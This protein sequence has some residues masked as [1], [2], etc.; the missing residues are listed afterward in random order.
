MDYNRLLNRAWTIVWTHKFLIGLGVVAAL[1]SGGNN[2][3][4]QMNDGNGASRSSF[5][6]G[7]ENFAGIS[8]VLIVLLIGLA[9]AVGLVLWVLVTVARGG[10]I[11]AVDTIDRGNNASFQTAWRAGWQKVWPL[12]G[13]ALLPAIPILLALVVGFITAGALTGFAAFARPNLD[14]PL[15][16]GVVITILALACLAA[17]F[18]LALILLRNF[19]ERACM[20]ENLG[21][22][23]A[24][25]RGW[26]VLMRNLGPAIILFLIQIVLTVLLSI[27]LLGPGIVMALCFLLWPVLLFISGTIAAYFS[28]LWTLAWRE[29]T[30]PNTGGSLTSSVAAGI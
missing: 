4:W 26:T 19:A 11:A 27:G 29:W 21:V 25:R 2:F 18:A 3:R 1:G 28:T 14:F 15:R 13:I 23:A 10:L 6:V 22:L 30:A 8:I 16:N 5:P 24:Y 12:L 9:L 17:P 20:L 7:M